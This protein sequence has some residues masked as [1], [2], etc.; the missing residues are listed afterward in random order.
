MSRLL[1]IADDFTGA[2]EMGAIAVAFGLTAQVACGHLPRAATDAL[3]V[4]TDT[5]HL[6]AGDAAR[7]LQSLLAHVEPGDFDFIYKKTDSVLRG[8]VAAELKTI[9]DALGFRRSLLVPQNPSRGRTIESGKYFID[10]KELH[11]TSFAEDPEF[12]ARTAGVRELLDP[13]NAF[14][15]HTRAMHEPLDESGIFI[16][17][18]SSEADID[19]WAS[20]LTEDTLAAGGADFFTANLR[21]RKL[22][23]GTLSPVEVETNGALFICG[24][25]SSESR[26]VTGGLARTCLMPKSLFHAGAPDNDAMEEWREVICDELRSRGR[27]VVAVGHPSVSQR[28][29]HVRRLLG[30]IA[31]RV[32]RSS[33][34]PSLFIEGGA[35]A[36]AVI[37]QLGWLDLAVV[38][39]LRPGVAVLRPLGEPG[40]TLVVKPGSYPWPADLLG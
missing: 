26:R 3:I 15:V 10:G 22:V 34:V 1:V 20:Q 39:Q 24:S 4:D 18:G 21:R 11:C 29:A 35:T 25:A 33:E 2:A 8:S 13:Q 12:P 37:E 14:V 32:M 9:A 31:A 7:R 36:A 19:R 30:E 17:Q 6:P 5:R 38:G 28:A 27:A 40:R 23:W 16:G